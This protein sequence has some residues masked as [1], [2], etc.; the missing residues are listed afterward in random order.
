MLHSRDLAMPRL[1]LGAII[2]ALVFAALVAVPVA[3][4]VAA[5]DHGD[6]TDPARNL[7]LPCNV[8][9]VQH[10]SRSSFNITHL[11]NSCG[12]VGTDVEF[13][14][15]VTADGKEHH[16]AFVGTMGYGFR[17]FD[18][19]DPRAASI[20]GG[21][22]DSGWQNDIQVRGDIAVS[23]FDGVAG[24]PSTASTCL[25][26]NYPTAF[27][28]GVDI[29]K[30]NFNAST[31]DFTVNLITCVANPPGGTHNSTLH[32]SGEWLALAN[33]SSDWAVDVVDLRNI[34]NG[35]AVHVYRLI[36]ESRSETSAGIGTAGPPGPRCPTGATF[37]CVVM[38][39]P[40]TGL[41]SNP[42]DVPCSPTP[43]GCPTTSP[44]GARSAFGLFRP[45]DIHFSADGNTMYVAA[46][47]STQIV[48]VTNILG[49][50]AFIAPG[51][52]QRPMLPAISI[53]PNVWCPRP[54]AGCGTSTVTGLNN[55]HNIQLSHQADITPDGAMLLITDERGGGI[56]ETRCNEDPAGVIGG[57]HFWALAPIAGVTATSAATPSNPVR[58]GAYFNP[59]PLLAVDPLA[60]AVNALP[61]TERACTSH[62]LRI[63][64]N[65]TM[66]PG[67]GGNFDGVSTLP[68]RQL[69]MGW[70]GAGVWYLD[71]SGP[72]RDDD[73]VAEEGS[74]PSTW[75]NTLGWN[76]MPGAETWSAKEYEGFIYAGD[77]TRGFDIYGC[78]NGVH[79]VTG[80][81]PSPA[82]TQAPTA[83]PIQSPTPRPTATGQ[84]PG[85]STPTPGAR[86]VPNTASG[87][88]AALVAGSFAILLAS[89]AALVVVRRRTTKPGA[90]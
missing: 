15:R 16:Y 18:V 47:N 86:Q 77:M 69:M 79:C 40:T 65:G 76:V 83:A 64:G 14:S 22:A 38:V 28:Q 78:G 27:G 56:Q 24:E 19:T 85:T 70:Y 37:T 6:E 43:P 46:L 23:T 26:T 2:L 82:P 73:G 75:G 33:S 71:F 66:S 32:P 74:P 88:G 68:N 53:I 25:Q 11:L 9:G 17:I 42:A 12:I 7:P 60:G 61:R 21:Y 10:P 45:H 4:Q 39:R 31:G 81:A 36:D 87:D 80:V 89:I 34:A 67:A 30:L 1:A 13:Q 52:G 62:V 41:G 63:G 48:N 51:A 54:D 44:Y 55:A 72:S 20:A 57:L 29:F 58:I 50:A 59:N 8:L 49:G 5:Q 90:G 3:T 35:Q 84:A